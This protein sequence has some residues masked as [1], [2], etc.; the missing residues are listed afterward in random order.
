MICQLCLE[1]KPLLKKS[2]IIPNFL[3]KDLFGDKHR[4]V[5]I[6]LNDISQKKYIQSGYWEKDILCQS[7]DNE[8]LGKLERYASNSIYSTQGENSVVKK[9]FFVGNGEF[10]PFIRISNLDFAKT[11]LFLLSI[12]WR[13]HLSTK[14]LF[15]DVRLG[16]YPEKIRKMILNHD[17]G[18]EDELEVVLI[19]LATEGTR[20][21]KSIISPRLIKDGGNTS[22]VFHINEITYHFNVSGYNKISLYE[23]GIIRNDGIMDMGIVDGSMARGYFDDYIGRTFLM[24]SNIKR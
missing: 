11:K 5:D 1:D 24:K 3:Y 21:S 17:A 4:L 9:E 2:H 6:N 19:Y 16:K 14:P 13:C 18:R 15:A 12:L 22:Y 20:P 8:I 23:K 7:C 10:M